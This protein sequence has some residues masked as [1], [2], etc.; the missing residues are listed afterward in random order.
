MRR[1]LGRFLLVSELKHVL[2]CVKALGLHVAPVPGTGYVMIDKL[3][4]G[5]PSWGSQAKEAGDEP[6]SKLLCG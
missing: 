3:D 1:E 2:L 5:P 4:R 6:A